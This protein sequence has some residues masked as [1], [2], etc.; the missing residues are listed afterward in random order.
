MLYMVCICVINGLYMLYMVCICVIEGFGVKGCLVSGEELG[1]LG[2]R[3]LADG[4]AS[5]EKGSKGGP[6]KYCNLRT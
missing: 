2:A 4:P 1:H 6:C 3:A 5:G